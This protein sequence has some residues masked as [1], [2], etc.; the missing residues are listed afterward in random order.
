MAHQE[1]ELLGLDAALGLWIVDVRLVPRVAV[2]AGVDDQD[3]AL[4]DRGP[5]HDHLGRVEAVVRY[6]VRDVYDDARAAQ[7]FQGMSAMALAPSERRSRPPGGCRPCCS[8]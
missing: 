3:V 4:F 7:I 6:R 5:L 2:V 1:A 8:N